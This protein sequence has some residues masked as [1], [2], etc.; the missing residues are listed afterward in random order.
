MCDSA[1]ILRQP[2]NN[3]SAAF[4]YDWMGKRDGTELQSKY[5]HKCELGRTEHVG[6]HRDEAFL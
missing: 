3:G 4:L 1:E 2:H 5:S 6:L